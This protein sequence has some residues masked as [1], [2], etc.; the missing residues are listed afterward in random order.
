MSYVFL[1]PKNSIRGLKMLFPVILRII[2]GE[3]FLEHLYSTKRFVYEFQGSLWSYYWAILLVST[4][5]TILEHFGSLLPA[6]SVTVKQKKWKIEKWKISIS[7][8]TQNQLKISES[9][10]AK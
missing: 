5:I 7:W 10:L 6:S 9:A 1:V 8:Q 4:V 2:F 3:I